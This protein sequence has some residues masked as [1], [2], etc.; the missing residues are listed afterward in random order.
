MFWRTLICATLVM[1]VELTSGL[2]LA[3]EDADLPKTLD[4]QGYL[5]FVGRKCDLQF[6]IER[7]A[8]ADEPRAEFKAEADFSSADD[9]VKKVS[10]RLHWLSFMPDEKHKLVIHVIDKRLLPVKN[11]PLEKV[12]DVEFAG[13]PADLSRYLRRQVPNIGPKTSGDPRQ[14][15]DDSFT[16]VA[17][18]A[19][20]QSI[21]RV[22]TDAVPLNYYGPILWRA[23]FDIAEDLTTL[24]FYGSK[25]SRQNRLPWWL[26]L[27]QAS[28]SLGCSFTV[29]TLYRAPDNPVSSAPYF[30]REENFDDVDSLTRE[31]TKRVP[32]LIALKDAKRPEI[33]H[34]ID[35]ELLKLRD[36]ALDQNLSIDFRGSPLELATSLKE[37]GIKAGPKISEATLKA[38]GGSDT[39]TFLKVRAQDEE[40]RMILTDGFSTTR[41]NHGVLWHARTWVKADGPHTSIE[42][43]HRR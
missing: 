14:V 39:K 2:T 12:V 27:H 24:Q 28:E 4:W 16:E 21:R 9:F 5:A 35:K 43:R 41:E 13:A 17:I 26:W 31:L 29:E 40:L 37:K 10:P 34:I 15:F 22:L 11:Y 23:E 42:F 33:V 6:T 3:A 1:L 18:A 8:N 30:G 20:A 19:K 7:V 25:I 36:Y 32:H 38:I